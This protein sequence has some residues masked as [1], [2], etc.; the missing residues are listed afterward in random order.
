MI[1][2]KRLYTFSAR[3]LGVEDNYPPPGDKRLLTDRLEEK[4]LKV[5]Q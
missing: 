2:N 1:M 4:I 5:P 3:P